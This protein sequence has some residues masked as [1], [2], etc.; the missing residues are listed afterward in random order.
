MNKSTLLVLL[1]ELEK[2]GLTAYVLAEK[3]SLSRTTLNRILKGEDVPRCHNFYFK[4]L[5][6]ELYEQ[7]LSLLRKMKVE[8]YNNIRK[9]LFVLMARELGLNNVF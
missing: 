1:E 3:H 5:A 9:L 8:E 6:T 2:F 7:S 4:V